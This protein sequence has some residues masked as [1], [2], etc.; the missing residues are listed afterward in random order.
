MYQEVRFNR[1]AEA[2]GVNV[3]HSLAPTPQVMLC[4]LQVCLIKKIAVR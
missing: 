1:R 2:G 4:L 3:G